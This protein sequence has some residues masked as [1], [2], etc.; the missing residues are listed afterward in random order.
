MADPPTPQPATHARKGQRFKETRKGD[1]MPRAKT[2]PHYDYV[3]PL[4]DAMYA[5]TGG[6]ANVKVQNTEAAAKA[7]EILGTTLEAHGK[8]DQTDQWW[9]VRWASLAML[10]LKA[11]GLMSFPIKGWWVLTEEGV[12]AANPPSGSNTPVAAPVAA[13]VAPVALNAQVAEMLESIPDTA[14]QV[15]D[16]YLLGLQ[17][18]A[19]PCFGNWS[20]KSDPCNRCALKGRCYEGMLAKLADMADSLPLVE[21]PAPPPPPPAQAFK[22]SAATATL[23]TNAFSTT[24]KAGLNNNKSNM[25]EGFVEM[26]LMA[27]ARC[28]ICGKDIPEGQQG[29]YNRKHG[30]AHVACARAFQASGKA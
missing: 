14:E 24:V 16:S 4:L 27:D 15:V 10:D 11:K 25:S 6:Q 23:D 26:A 22:P 1:T 13:P 12:Q 18:A 9:T 28:T 30:F 29:A 20:P 19:T 2:S 7:C 8:Q 21:Q 3:Q 5:L 17:M